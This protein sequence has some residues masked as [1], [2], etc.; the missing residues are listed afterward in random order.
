MN[1]IHRMTSG[2]MKG[3]L[4]NDSR[5]SPVTADQGS[6]VFTVTLATPAAGVDA[7]LATGEAPVIGEA[8][9]LMLATGFLGGFSTFSTAINEM[10]TLFKEHRYPT[11]VGYLA[12]SVVTPVAAAAAGFLPLV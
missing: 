1:G 9:R 4:R 8:W 11:A 10:V 12:A 5:C 6:T 2:S 7:A 3:D